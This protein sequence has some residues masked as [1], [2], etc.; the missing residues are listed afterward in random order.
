MRHVAT[1]ASKVSWKVFQYKVADS[2]D[3]VRLPNNLRALVRRENNAGEDAVND[4][5]QSPPPLAFQF[6]F[7][8]TVRDFSIVWTG[9]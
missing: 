7:N 3:K 5:P 2:L 1:M 4:N 9:V 6:V 8:S